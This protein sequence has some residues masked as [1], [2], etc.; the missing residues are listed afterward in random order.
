MGIGGR[1]LRLTILPPSCVDCLEIWEPQPPVT[2]RACPVLYWDFFTFYL[3]IAKS[4][5]RFN[6]LDPFS[7]GHLLFYQSFFTTV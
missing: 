5:Q 2:L 4:F 1:C 3:F 7:A 6:P